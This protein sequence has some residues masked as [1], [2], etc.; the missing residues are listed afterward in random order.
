M[1]VEL[2]SHEI[3]TTIIVLPASMLREK[4]YF[5]LSTNKGLCGVPSLP[6]CPF[7]WSNGRLSSGGKIAI[8]ITCLVVVCVVLLVI[9]ICVR[10]KRNDYDF[11]LPH[12][13][14]CKL[15]FFYICF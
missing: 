6:E 9:Y 14:M 10:R 13:L 8:G 7:L 1:I 12:E 5:S 2:T 3:Y 11:G 15:I 4:L